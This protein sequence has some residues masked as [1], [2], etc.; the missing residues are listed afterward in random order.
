MVKDIELGKVVP[1]TTSENQILDSKSQ[2]ITAAQSLNIPSSEGKTIKS[3]ELGELTDIIPEPEKKKS[4]LG[5][6][7]W[8]LQ[9]VFASICMGAGQFLYASNFSK[10]GIMGTGFI[11]PIP[12]VL[13]IIMRLGMQLK[14]RQ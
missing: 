10:H 11:G 5:I 1:E 6:Q 4:F 13:L 14:E 3:T 2:I 9:V 12:M 8:F 7:I